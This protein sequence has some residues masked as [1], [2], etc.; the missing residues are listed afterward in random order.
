MKQPDIGIMAMVH[1]GVNA[2]R[3]RGGAL[4]YSA[5]RRDG[6]H[7]GVASATAY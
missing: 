7:R 6:F 3:N 4:E 2:G 5:E 1:I